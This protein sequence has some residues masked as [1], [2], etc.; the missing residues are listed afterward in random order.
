MTKKY[1]KKYGRV[2]VKSVT[3]KL[4]RNK[5]MRMWNVS[6]K[7]LCKNHLCAEH[8]ELHALLGS[9]RKGISMDGYIR[10]GLVELD[11]IHSRHTSLAHEMTSRGYNHKTPI[12]KE[13]LTQE[14]KK[15]KKY[16]SVMPWNSMVE[17]ARR[18]PE[19]RKRLML[20]GRGMLFMLSGLAD[21]TLWSRVD[22]DSIIKTDAVLRGNLMS[23]GAE[24]ARVLR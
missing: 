14:L 21:D 6:A 17:L 10:N 2:K 12:K 8:R 13:E 11:K 20:D 4:K 19:C 7:F 18:C 24:V 22:E 15:Y 16:G 3:R 23:W 9:M 5:I 1:C